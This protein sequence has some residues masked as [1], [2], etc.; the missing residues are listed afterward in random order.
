VERVVT[1]ALTGEKPPIPGSAVSEDVGCVC[2]SERDASE[3]MATAENPP[4]PNAAA[5]SAAKLL[6]QL[7]MNIDA[8][9]APKE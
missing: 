3:V 6:L 7:A 8:G 9:P 1:N 2:L 5:L 4:T